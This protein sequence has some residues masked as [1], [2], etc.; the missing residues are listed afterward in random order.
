MRHRQDGAYAVIV[1]EGLDRLRPFIW[2]NGGETLPVK[3]YGRPTGALRAIKVEP[4]RHVARVAP[5]G[6]R[7]G[8]GVRRT[9]L[10]ARRAGVRH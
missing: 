2:L 10:T 7:R 1:R 4:S 9:G 6:R 5:A 8:M 3:R